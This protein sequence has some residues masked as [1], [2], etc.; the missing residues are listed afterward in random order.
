MEKICDIKKFKHVKTKKE[1]K[2]CDE[3]KIKRSNKNLITSYQ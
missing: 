2:T 1:T 3:C